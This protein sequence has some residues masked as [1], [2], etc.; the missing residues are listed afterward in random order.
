MYR[1]GYRSPRYPAHF[2]VRLTMCGSVQIVRC[3]NISA[4]GMTLKAGNELS[5]NARGQVSFEYDQMSFD[6][7]ACVAHCGSAATG[8]RFLYQ[9]EGQRNAVQEM[10]GRLSACQANPVLHSVSPGN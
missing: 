1:F 8:L 2:P 10:I 6:L 9:T 7:R 3:I 4:E 5:Q